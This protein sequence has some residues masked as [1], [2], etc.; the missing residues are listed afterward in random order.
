MTGCWPFAL[1]PVNAKLGSTYSNQRVELQG[2]KTSHYTGTAAI[3]LDSASV[4]EHPFHAA[5]GLEANASN[6]GW[7][8]EAGWMRRIHPSIRLGLHG[9]SEQLW[10]SGGGYGLRTGLTLEYSSKHRR[11]AKSEYDPGNDG[12]H[13]QTTTYWATSGSWGIGGF[14]DIG[15][16]WMENDPDINYVSFGLLIRFPAIAGVIDLTGIH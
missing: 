9:A 5:I 11:Y 4:S 6:S 2:N 14:L 16:R 3:A 15:H 7:Y 8:V 13:D 1:P 10:A 12:T